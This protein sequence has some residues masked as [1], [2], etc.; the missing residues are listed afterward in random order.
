MESE[1]LQK[2]D[3]IIKDLQGLFSKRTKRSKPLNSK[4]MNYIDAI[5][6]LYENIHLS[7]PEQTAKEMKSAE[8]TK[9][10]FQNCYL[11]LSSLKESEYFFALLEWSKSVLEKFFKMLPKENQKIIL[12]DFDKK[13][14]K[15]SKVN[16]QEEDITKST[17]EVEELLKTIEKL[18]TE[19]EKYKK[20]LNGVNNYVESFKNPTLENILV[21]LYVQSKSS[22]NEELK[23]ELSSMMESCG[24]VPE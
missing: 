10:I 8:E 13:I 4:V 9:K 18:E 20:I 21:D 19:N 2:V 5:T 17:F 24:I 11:S 15:E 6:V 23:K 7:L 3:T 12:E 14:V 16:L 22:E 1:I